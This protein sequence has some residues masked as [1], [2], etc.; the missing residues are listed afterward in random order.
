MVEWWFEYRRKREL[1]GL[2]KK[3]TPDKKVVVYR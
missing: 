1:P 2:E 3:Q